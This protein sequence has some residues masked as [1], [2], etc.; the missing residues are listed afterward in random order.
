MMVRSEEKRVELLRR[1]IRLSEVAD[2]KQEL[3][4]AAGCK[5]KQCLKALRG[6]LYCR[7]NRLNAC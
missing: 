1:K 7:E 2:R 3:C 6:K 4:N 5:C